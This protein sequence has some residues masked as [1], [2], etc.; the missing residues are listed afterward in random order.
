MNKLFLITLILP[1]T[2]L[3]CPDPAAIKQALQSKLQGAA[4]AA[5][6]NPPVAPVQAN[7]AAAVN[8][9][10]V[11]PATGPARAG[12][13]TPAAGGPNMQSF[14]GTVTNKSIA[15]MR[16][17]I[18]KFK[19]NLDAMDGCLDAFQKVL[20]QPKDMIGKNR[21]FYQKFL[22]ATP[23]QQKQMTMGSE[24]SDIDKQALAKVQELMTKIPAQ[25][26]KSFITL[27]STQLDKASK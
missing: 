12:G 23:D 9:Q 20:G 5:I 17:D 4:G 16:A 15:D 25:N 7:P 11:P 14:M 26:G 18:A 21:D 13:A 10:A 1:V 3:Y 8:S 22:A 19:V 24:F 27:I 6:A 2:A